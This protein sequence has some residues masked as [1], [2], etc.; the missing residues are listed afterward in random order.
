VD[1][2]YDKLSRDELIG[3]LEMRGHATLERGLLERFVLAFH[4]CPD[5]ILITRR[6]D[7][8]IIEANEAFDRVYGVPAPQVVGRTTVEL[9]IWSD[10]S[11]RN[12]MLEKLK[13]DGRLR[14][15]EC[16]ITVHSG[17]RR[18]GNVSAEPVEIDGEACLVV[19]FRDVTM[20]MRT[21]R[22]L[23]ESEARFHNLASAAFEGIGI[24]EA[25]RLVEVNDQLANIL[26]YTR[27]ELIGHPVSELVAPESRP[28]V[29]QKIREGFPGL[30]E[31]LAIRKDGTI[32][33]VE[34]Q[35]RT[36]ISGERKLRV[37]SIRDVTVRKA[38]EES[39]RASE[40]RLRATIE[41]TPHVAVQWYDLQGRVLFWNQASEAM[42]GWSPAEATGKTL[43]HLIHTPEEAA[44]FLEVLRE[45]ERTGKSFG[46]SEYHFRRRDGSEGDC[47]S[48]TF[49]IPTGTGQFCFVCMDVDI[50]RQKQAVE[51]LRKSE[52]RFELAV[53]GSNDG[54]WDWDLRT[55]KVYN[56]P[57]LR[58][59]VGYVPAEN[60]DF[61]EA[62]AGIHPEDRDRV[63]AAIQAHLETRA[64][65]DEEFRLM[66][67]S[68]QYRW[69][70][71]RAQAVWDETGKATRMAG[72]LS[73]IHDHRLA[74][75]SLRRAQ[76]Q[77][78]IAR[79]EFTQRL[80]SAQEQERKRL[81]AELHDSLGQNLSLIKNRAYLASQQPGLPA[82]AASHLEAISDI[83]TEAISETRNLAHNLRP[84]HID[85]FGLTDALEN[86]VQQAGQA[87]AIQFERRFEDVD[88]LFRGEEA[89]NIY[90]MVQEALN[91]LV[92]HSQ[93]TRGGVRVERD[94]H[95]VRIVIEDNGCGFDLKAVEATRRVRT[96]I[97]L[98]SVGER[99][100]MLG[101][102]FE[103]KSAPGSGTRI[104]I[105]LPIAAAVRPASP[106]AEKTKSTTR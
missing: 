29:E 36:F 42:F 55:N 11:D 51:A 87:T 13:A 1:S 44:G 8:K 57:R 2:R 31:H 96:G 18:T 77:A 33:P 50:T 22:S 46:P 45:I 68:G 100:R 60:Q 104:Q 16:V 73:D 101:G 3:L 84:L 106:D 14:N 41:N 56:S 88:D 69:F 105:E 85:R 35:A 80:I 54:I 9:G 53:R 64:R 23:R 10:V 75:E 102:A 58:E 34:V 19:V 61:K 63:A 40:E 49:R 6:H 94:L 98:T 62:L 93:A 21:E 97:G 99:A 7:G 28:L 25:G 103:V 92:K 65:Y 74:E 66:S 37:T 83:V 17:E 12:R 70:R 26:G 4:A 72:S 78:L 67:A 76:E 47:L 5:P 27:D 38:A 81:A 20:Q 86:L 52:E 71:A 43:D 89:T 32:F 90:R 82:S 79:E 39:Y 24:C 95:R 48:T 59:L 91:N 30:Y 15:F